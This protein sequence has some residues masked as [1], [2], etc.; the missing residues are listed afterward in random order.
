MTALTF[1]NT[2]FDIVDH[3]GHGW[4]RLFQIGSALGYADPSMLV[5]VYQRHADEFTDHMTALV[6]LP[7]AG[8]E[9]ET[10][11]FSLRGAH[12]LGMLAK[13][14]IAKQFRKWVLDVLDNT[15]ASISYDLPATLKAIPG[16]LTCESQDALKAAVRERLEH[17]PKPRQGQAARTLWGALNTKF[18]TKGLKDGYK[19]IPNEALQECLSL[20][21][22][23]PLPGDTAP[24]INEFDFS[25][26]AVCAYLEAK[27]HR[28]RF[29]LSQ[30]SNGTMIAMSIPDDAM[31]A[32]P[33][34]LP[35]MI[36]SPDIAMP[37]PNTLLPEIIK[38]A[39]HRL[40]A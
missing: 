19:N 24:P 28:T 9:Q 29:L 8:G 1:Q 31:I 15:S 32:L 4:L 30:T 21:S 40:Q 17:I 11:I 10:R 36:A 16:K 3:N 26:K 6:K 2:T 35:K 33:R 12:L 25:D 13:T 23:V 22:R 37:N 7:S 14:A 20:V 39:A 34:E 27:L 38:A 18:G 5:R